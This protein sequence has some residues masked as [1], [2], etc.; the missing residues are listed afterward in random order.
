[1][2]LSGGSKYV[3]EPNS[4]TGCASC[5]YTAFLLGAPL[6]ICFHQSW[7]S[8][9]FTSC[10]IP[11]LSISLFLSFFAFIAF[12]CVFLPNFAQSFCASFLTYSGVSS[13]F[14]FLKASFLRHSGPISWNASAMSERVDGHSAFKT[15]STCAGDI[16]CST[17]YS[18]FSTSF[19]TVNF[20]NIFSFLSNPTVVS[21]WIGASILLPSYGLPYKFLI[22]FAFSSL[23]LFNSKSL[24]TRKSGTFHSKAAMTASFASPKLSRSS[25]VNF[26]SSWSSNLPYAHM[27]V[28][29]SKIS[30]G[31]LACL[32]NLR[33]SCTLP[34]TQN[35][36]IKNRLVPSKT[37][38]YSVAVARTSLT[39][40]AINGMVFLPPPH[41]STLLSKYD[42]FN[43]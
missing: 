22:L 39:K 35:A 5:L 37:N 7:P 27:P 11:D 36:S 40:L 29:L 42:D 4:K 21:T 24:Q 16:L 20:R 8:W 14:V 26:P 43:A 31:H 38:A 19:W 41:S 25:S 18:P 9:S 1:M 32:G 6:A 12:S 3:E 17:W 30:S 13:I 10:V 28:S 23:L 2:C 34:L 33:H 15:F